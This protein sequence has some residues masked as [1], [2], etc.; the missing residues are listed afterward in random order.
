MIRPS[1]NEM[2]MIKDDNNE[3]AMM[4]WIL[5]SGSQG[6]VGEVGN[7]SEDVWNRGSSTVALLMIITMTIMIK[8]TMMTAMTMMKVTI[9]RIKL[10]RP[11]S[12]LPLS[13]PN[14]SSNS[15]SKY[16]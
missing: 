8:M 14:P 6:V 4:A 1:N 3:N 7:L 5:D 2:K 12:L 16:Y 9:N 13:C 10:H 11:S 15:M